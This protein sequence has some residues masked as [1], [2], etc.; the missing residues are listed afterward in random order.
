MAEII[1]K[2]A[3]EEDIEK[4]A[5]IRARYSATVE[6][7]TERITN[8]YKGYLNP[9]KALAE[10][11]IYIA[12]DNNDIIAFVAG[13]LSTRYD[14][15]G[16]LQWIDTIESYR[17]KGIATALLKLLGKW[18]IEHKAYKICVDPG[19]PIAR[20]F[21]KRNGADNLNEHW[22]FWNDIRNVV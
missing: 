6:Y 11:V 10:R 1:Y 15:Q 19:N 4:I 7:W 12:T 18:F 8:Y 20:K 13:H 14:C 2:I 9:Q 22:M 16:E 3:A 21:C 5:A 17:S